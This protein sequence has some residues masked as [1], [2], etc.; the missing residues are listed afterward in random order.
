VRW[1]APQPNAKTSASICARA[2]ASGNRGERT[3]RCVFSV[4]RVTEQ[5]QNDFSC[6]RTLG[7]LFVA[8]QRCETSTVKQGR[9]WWSVRWSSL[10]GGG[11]VCGG[12]HAY[13]REMPLG[14][15]QPAA[16][17]TIVGE[18]LSWFHDG[19]RPT[20]RPD[21]EYPILIVRTCFMTTL[22]HSVIK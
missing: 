10:W 14:L 6:N 19:A 16:R 5:A 20:R 2:A 1:H 18:A 8:I 4:F 11:V 7:G 17:R 9:E 13:N 22:T 3:P 21:H 12:L 15:T